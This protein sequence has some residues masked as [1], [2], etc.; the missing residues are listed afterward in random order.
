M[1]TTSGSIA[2]SSGKKMR[3]VAFAEPR[4]LHRRLADD[5]RGIDRIAAVRDARDVKRRIAIREAIDAG[6]IAERSLDAQVLVVDVSL[7][8]ELGVGRHHQIDGLR[9]RSARPACRAGDRQMRTRRASGGSGAVAAY[10]SAGS[11]P[12]ATATGT[13]APQA[14]ACA[15]PC[16]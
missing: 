8:H 12:I 14:S 15:R 10:V 13:V 1:S 11:V 3:S 9:A 4:V 7:E 16:L 5:G 2:C 6:V